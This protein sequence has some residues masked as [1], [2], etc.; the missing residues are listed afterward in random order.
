MQAGDLECDEAAVL[1]R[2]D[3]GL[4]RTWD[5]LLG[6]MGRALARWPAFRRLEPVEL[7]ATAN[8][9]AMLFRPAIA[10]HRLGRDERNRLANVFSERLQLGL[11]PEQL[12]AAVHAA[13]AAG[14]LH[15]W[16]VTVDEEL[17][18]R[19]S[20]PA[21]HR[22]VLRLWSTVDDLQEVATV[23]GDG[24]HQTTMTTAA[25]A[26]GADA[27]T[28]ADMAAVQRASF[29]RV[30]LE[31]DTVWGLIGV[32]PGRHRG[33][34]LVEATDAVATATGGASG[35]KRSDPVG[36]LMVI[37]PLPAAAAPAVRSTWDVVV[38]SARQ[39]LWWQ[40]AALLAAPWP[41]CATDITR[42][43]RW[44]RACLKYAG[45]LPGATGLAGARVE[46]YHDA[47]LVPPPDRMAFFRRTL[48]PLLVDRN[49][50]RLLRSLDAVVA[51]DN[52][53]QTSSFLE[54][55]EPSVERHVGEVLRATGLDW[56]DGFGRAV[57]Q[58]AV[59][60]RWL[61]AAF[62]GPYDPAWGPAP[63][64]RELIASS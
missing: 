56:A 20:L 23:A 22:A 59:V 64:L 27:E 58:R 26:P 14:Y 44:L 49:G 19:A 34:D 30:A 33:V 12:R 36:H 37:V 53:R 39:A 35:P 3:A 31:A 43:E 29:R 40:G 50:P 6:D 32:V 60:Y 57:V 24:M 13:A 54:I 5:L 11:A 42:T 21:V 28:E 2:L 48:G 17:H 62:D 47:E 15:L 38:K 4:G 7:R 10:G 45:V 1:A 16:S 61:A 46:W 52:P 55:S 63:P 8:G 25:P 18:G 41:V 9:L 51:F